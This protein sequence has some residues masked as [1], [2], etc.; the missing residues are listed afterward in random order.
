[1]HLY[2]LS[3]GLIRTSFSTYEHV[4]FID[5]KAGDGSRKATSYLERIDHDRFLGIRSRVAQVHLGC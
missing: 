4:L 1:M 5:S 3:R 2:L